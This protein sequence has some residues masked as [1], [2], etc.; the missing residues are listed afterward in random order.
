MCF[1][2]EHFVFPDHDMYP[3]WPP[4][5]KSVI[6]AMGNFWHAERI[7]LQCPGIYSTQVGYT[8]G[9]TPN[10]TYK[11]IRTGM[12]NHAGNYVIY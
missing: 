8:G 10:P 9:Q 12:T 11:E 2:N 1:C 7:F 4:M 3:P 5:F 6:F